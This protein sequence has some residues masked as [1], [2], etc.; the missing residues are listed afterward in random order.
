[1]S[2]ALVLGSAQCVDDDIARAAAIGEF[3][4][5]VACNG[6]IERW[7]VRLDAAVTLHPEKLNEWLWRRQDN[8]Y[9]PP[10]CVVTSD[11]YECASADIKTAPRMPGQTEAGSSG[12]FAVKVALC[13][14]GYDK[15]ICCGI[16]LTSMPHAGDIEPW[17]VAALYRGGWVQAMEFMKRRVRSMSGWTAD[18]LGQPTADWMAENVQSHR[19]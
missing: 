13:D 1:M 6:M 14:L 5:V 7:P 2:V 3:D 18:F 19:V 12:L 8:G 11:R 17:S 4:G 10:R 15:V 9:P 16:P